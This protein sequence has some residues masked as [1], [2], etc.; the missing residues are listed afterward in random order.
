MRSHDMLCKWMGMAVMAVT[1][2]AC[3]GGGE[4]ET[5][6]EPEAAAV[7]ER[8]TP[9][10]EP[11]SAEEPVAENETSV[12][13]P[14]GFPKIIPM[15]E[16]F[17]VESVDTKDAAT[18]QF[19]VIGLAPL[20]EVKL[21]DWYVAEWTKLGWEEDMLMEQKGYT[22]VSYS[23][24]NLLVVIESIPAPGGCRSTITTGTL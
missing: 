18:N 4:E 9:L 3:G 1:L 12:A 6:T 5:V 14:D 24:D 23:K 8:P 19:T 16:G 7:V 20:D 21:M 2:A 11:A 13:L 10:R 15:I 22:I 17:I